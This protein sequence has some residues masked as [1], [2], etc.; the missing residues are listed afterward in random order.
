MVLALACAVL[1]V[2]APTDAQAQS[3]FTN[4]ATITIPSSGTRTVILPVP[5]ISPNRT[6]T[7]T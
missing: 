3:T 4:S 2:L 6:W 5:A 1:S 7:A